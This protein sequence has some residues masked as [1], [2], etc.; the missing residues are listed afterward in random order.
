MDWDQSVNADDEIERPVNPPRSPT[1]RQE[2]ASYGPCL[3]LGPA[4]QRCSQP[5]TANGFCLRHQPDGEAPS[6]PARSSRRIAVV[7]AILALL[8]PVLVDLIRAL[9]RLFR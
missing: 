6:L 3:Y 4:G 5:A 2:S 7:M 1:A 9:I 8:W